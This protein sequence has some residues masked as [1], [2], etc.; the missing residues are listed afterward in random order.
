MVKTKR[1][2]SPDEIIE[3]YDPKELAIHEAFRKDPLVFCELAVNPPFIPNKVQAEVL[4]APLH[5]QRSLLPWMRGGGKS[6][7]ISYK[8]AHD[9]FRHRNFSVFL[10]SPAEE[11][12]ALIFDKV[13]RIYKTSDYL[14]ENVPHRIKGDIFYVGDEKWGSTLTLLKVGLDA[15]TARGRHVTGG[16]GY[17]C[18]DEIS[19]HLYA[20]KI[21]DVLEPFITTGGGLVYLSSPGEASDDNYMWHTY[22]DWRA[23]EKLALQEGRKPKHRVY[24][25]RLRDCDH[26]NRD[27]VREQLRKHKNRGT[28][29]LFKREYLGQWNQT[30]GSYFKSQDI[31]ACTKANIDQGDK[32]STYCWAIDP[33][34]QQASFVIHI[35]RLN[36]RTETMEIV[37]VLSYIFEGKYRKDS[38]DEKITEFEQILDALL[39][40]RKRFPPKLVYY[41]PNC[42]RALSERMENQFHFPMKAKLIGGYDS[43]A[44]SLAD[45]NRALQDRTIAFND[46]RIIKQLSC[47]AP[48]LKPNGEYDF[49]KRLTDHVICLAMIACYLGDKCIP[50]WGIR[51]GKRKW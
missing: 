41:D 50:A 18:G 6:H 12:S 39:E 38:G 26:I 29:W 42:E 4:Q 36:Q 7:T 25:L 21:T 40:V 46:T 27:E 43:K 34:G 9:L 14:S 48:K 47:F 28:L 19:S 44:R 20:Q 17:L 13:C 8:I 22:K 35:A 37:R 2:L 16:N 51:T 23:M 32:H 49:P 24:R 3:S 45:L 1:K 11:Q 30:I 15:R 31:Q 5:E 10:F 33:G